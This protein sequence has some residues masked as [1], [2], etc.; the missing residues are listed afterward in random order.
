[1][2]LTPTTLG[3][4]IEAL[5]ML[6]GFALLG[7][8]IAN[9]LLF[10]SPYLYLDPYTWFSTPSDMA[11]FKWIDIFVEASFYPIFAMLFGY[12]LNMQYEKA[13]AN[14]YAICS[15]YG[16]SFRHITC[17][18]VCSM[19]CLFGLGTFCSLMR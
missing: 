3:N 19:H 1:M 7:I 8:F 12:G 18:S 5:D 2:K 10:H 11:T 17:V 14:R 6:R 4:R 13:I 9:M 15:G 16:T